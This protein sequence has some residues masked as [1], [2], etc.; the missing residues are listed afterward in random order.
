ME[1]TYTYID[2]YNEL[3]QIVSEIELGEVNVDELAVK[4]ER[5]SLLINICKSK[6]TASEA[7]VQELLNQLQVEQAEES[8]S[9]EEDIEEDMEEQ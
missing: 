8:D 5:A 6:L 9:T 3:Q 1:T 2:A 4:I 7:Q